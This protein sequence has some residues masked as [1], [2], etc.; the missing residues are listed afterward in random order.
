MIKSETILIK[1]LSKLINC[2]LPLTTF[3]STLTSPVMPLIT[4]EVSLTSHKTNLTNQLSSFTQGNASL[5]SQFFLLP[6]PPIG[7]N[8]RQNHPPITIIVLSN[9]TRLEVEK[10][11]RKVAQH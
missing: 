3:D 10:L 2:V 9:Q 11:E 1:K 6:R 7:S 5:T 8:C 4:P